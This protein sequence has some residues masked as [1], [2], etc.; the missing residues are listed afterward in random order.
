MEDGS[1]RTGALITNYRERERERED[2]K[3]TKE[4]LHYLV[5]LERPVTRNDTKRVY[6]VSTCRLHGRTLHEDHALNELT[7]PKRLSHRRKKPEK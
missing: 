6:N 1:A 2:Q 5:C 3:C 7:R 4:M